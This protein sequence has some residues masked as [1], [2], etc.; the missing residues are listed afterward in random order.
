M[1]TTET[2]DGT[3]VE[4]AGD[5]AIVTTRDFAAPPATVHRAFHDPEIIAQWIG[6]EYLTN[7][8][9]TGGTEHGDTWTLVQQ[10]P[11][12]N[13]YAFRGVVHG[14]A[15]PEL[16]H[17]TFEW[18]GMAGHVSMEQLRL[19]DLGDGTTR[20]HAI[21]L[22]ASAEDRDGMF[23]SMGDGGYVRLDPLLATL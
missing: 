7:I 6:P 4:K 8:E 10:D 9:V 18:L 1:T 2:R 17:R 22:F 14:T 15:T 23:E 12:G 13:Q 11:D 19:E 16:T 21:S 20:V 3:L 5:H